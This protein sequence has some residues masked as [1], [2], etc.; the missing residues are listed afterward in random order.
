MEKILP[1]KVAAATLILLRERADGPPQILMIERGKTLSFASGNMV[2]PG[3][4]VDADD[5][6]IATRAD[7]LVPGAE[8]EAEDLVARIAAVRETLEETGLAPA[9]DRIAGQ[10]QLE[11]MRND[12]EAGKPFSDILAESG[13]RIDPYQLI[14]F[15]RWIPPVNKFSNFDTRFYIAAEPALGEAKVDGSESSRCCWLA[16]DDHI[17]AGNMIFPTLRNVER[18]GQIESIAHARNFCARYPIRIVTPWF[19]DRDG[20]RWLCIPDDLGYPVTSAVFTQAPRGLEAPS[21]P[22]MTRAPG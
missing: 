1:E 7:L 14:P 2:F 22:K 16:A 8:I 6:A 4:K 9:V 10:G 5:H 11:Q 18:A 12:L 13:L 21:S 20:E 19:E 17:S 15:A 3:G